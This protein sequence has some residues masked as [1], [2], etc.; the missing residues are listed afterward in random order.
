[1][2]TF[3]RFFASAICSRRK[4]TSTA[5]TRVTASESISASIGTR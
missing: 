5:A 4:S 2:T 3:T 1:M